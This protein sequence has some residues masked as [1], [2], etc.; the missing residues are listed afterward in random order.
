MKRETFEFKNEA[1]WLGMRRKFVTSTEA[2]GLFDA[3]SYEG[4]RTYFDLYAK[5]AGLIPEPKFDS[6]ND[7]IRWGNFLEPAI[8][9]GI[10]QTYGVKVVPFK[11]FITMP[12][13]GLASSFDYKIVGIVDG[14]E[15]DQ[16]L[17]DMFKEHGEGIAEI[18]NVDALQ[19]RR[20][21]IEDKETMEATLQIEMQVQAQME[22]SDY[23]WCCIAALVGG[24]TPKI[25]IRTRD[26][27]AGK[28]I[29]EKAKALWTCVD[30][31]KAPQPNFSKDAETI[32][33][34]YVNNNGLEIDV[35]GNG[36]V[37]ELCVEY[38]KASAEEKAAEDRKKAAKAELLTIIQG[39]KKAVAGQFSISAGTNKESYRAYHKE[40][41]ERWT[42]TKS[43]VPACDVEATVPAYRN[44]RISGGV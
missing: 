11:T 42:I 34:L 25:I 17:R 36:R 14:F 33:K 5:K 22:V 12:E 35:S 37:I 38:K 29:R 27:D 44:V 24:N 7:R 15:G 10:A 32:S 18:K 4:S 6:D 16:S 19:F 40:A 23:P 8:A 31:G 21:W 2:A 39:A 28:A 3:G 9:S 1:D 30:T 41:G 43:V 26:T 13:F 20:N